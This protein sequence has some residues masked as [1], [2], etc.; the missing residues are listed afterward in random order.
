MRFLLS[1]L[2]LLICTACPSD[3][4][5]ASDDDDT[6]PQD[7]DDSADPGC[8]DFGF[9]GDDDDTSSQDDDDS[10]P[11]PTPVRFVALGDTGE[12]FPKTV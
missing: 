8:T 11:E 4:Q 1:S 7:D 3:P 12:G 10:S 9:L 6:P 2:V 5:P